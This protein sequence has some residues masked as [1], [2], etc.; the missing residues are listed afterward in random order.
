MFWATLSGALY[1]L[2]LSLLLGETLL[3]HSL[4]G[5]LILAGLGVIVQAGGQGFIAYGVGRLPIV[6]STVLLWMQPLAA[7]VLSWI[8]FGEELGAFALT[9]AALI[10]AGLF[11]VQRSRPALGADATKE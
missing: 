11:V 6:V 7:A 2:A 5:W 8:I 4:Q 3:P 10:L 1:A 9:G